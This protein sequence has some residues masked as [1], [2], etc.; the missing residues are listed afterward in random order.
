MPY[1]VARSSLIVLVI[2][3]ATLSVISQTADEMRIATAS[4]RAATAAYKAKNYQQVLF[5]H[6]STGKKKAFSFR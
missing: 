2:I 3:S 1:H 4:E 6:P 5:L